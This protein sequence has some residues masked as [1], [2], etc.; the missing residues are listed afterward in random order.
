MASG[1]RSKMGAGLKDRTK[2]SFGRKDKSGMFK[3]YLDPSK[4]EGLVKFNPGKGTWIIDIIPY[5]AGSNDPFNKK[6]EVAYVL[7]ILVHTQVGP[8]DDRIVCPVQYG[9]PCPICEEIKRLNT[10]GA[11]YKTEIK[12]LSAKRRT[13]YNVI[14]RENPEE[15]KKGMQLLEISHYFLE[16]NIA[17]LTKNPRKGGYIVFSDPDTG[18]SVSFRRTGVGAESTAYDAYQFIDRPEPI[19][20]AELEAARCLD[21]LIVVKSYEE[22]EE[23]FN[24]RRKPEEAPDNSGESEGA[25]EEVVTPPRAGRKPPVVEPPDEGDDGDE[26]VVEEKTAP[27]VRGA[28]RG[29]RKN[30]PVCPVEEGTLG[31]TLDEFVECDSCD[32]YDA[33]ADA[34]ANA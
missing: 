24:A 6:G 17:A 33:C 10:A 5:Y 23:I 25:G 1:I 4:T 28:R 3:D 12:P 26:D 9:R 11:D 22:I 31:V 7:D 15:E 14:V 16:K 34:V 19:S 21:D 2:E 29:T 13:M 30:T 32:H 18:K 20:D 27:P 8:A